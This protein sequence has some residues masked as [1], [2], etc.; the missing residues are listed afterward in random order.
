MKQKGA[1]L[2]GTLTT[3]SHVQCALLQ[4]SP[5]SGSRLDFDPWRCLGRRGESYRG[6]CSGST[7]L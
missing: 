7:N 2:L 1:W 3:V 5:I 4:L 6:L